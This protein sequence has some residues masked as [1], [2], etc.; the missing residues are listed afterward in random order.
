MHSRT[1]LCKYI[2]VGSI[3]EM[4]FGDTLDRQNGAAH[5][6]VYRP[7]GLRPLDKRRGAPHHIVYPT[8][9]QHK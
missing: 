5:H 9:L 4:R 8:G 3:C 1:S 2:Q 7:R 6:L